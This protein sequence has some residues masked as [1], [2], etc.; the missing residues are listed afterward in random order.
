MV[1]F[2]VG[3]KNQ[4]KHSTLNL[5]FDALSKWY[6]PDIREWAAN[7]QSVSTI[8]TEVLDVVSNHIYVQFTGAGSKQKFWWNGFESMGN[9]W[10][11]NSTMAK[12]HLESDSALSEKVSYQCPW[13]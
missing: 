8:S 4:N 5:S 1:S 9:T 13:N 12:K 3:W 6:E 11:G 2:H 7:N 10:S